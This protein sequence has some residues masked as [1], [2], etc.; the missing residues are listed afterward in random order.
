MTTKPLPKRAHLITPEGEQMLKDEHD[1]L[2]KVERPR[3]TQQ[4]SDAAK[5]GDR[6]ENAEYIYGKKRL[7]QIDSRLRFLRKRLEQVTVVDRR[8]TDE[9]KVYF[10]A[11]IVLQDD[12][13]KDLHYRIVGEDE[14]DLARGYISVDAPLARGL[15]GKS[16]GDDVAVRLP[17][18]EVDYYIAEVVY[19]VPTW[20]PGRQSTSRW[21]EE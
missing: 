15:L 5:L 17:K 2:W 20:D 8:P 1:F 9:Q 21:V 16:E 4:V 11:W 18:G 10:G 7:R 14:I 19:D 13:D 12:D 3:V 6:S